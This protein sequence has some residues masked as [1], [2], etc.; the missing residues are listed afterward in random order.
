MD[1]DDENNVD[2][3][4]E[5]T[6]D[7]EHLSP[8]QPQ[9]SDTPFSP[10][11]DPIEDANS[12]LDIREV[13]GQLNPEHPGTDT[14]VDSQEAYDEGISGAAEAEE[15]NAGDNVVNYDPTK[16]QRKQSS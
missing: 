7:G 4:L 9:D 3:A 16:D 5:V 6:Q 10:P 14:N 12:E 1:G 13:E 15:P 8:K 11:V 2:D